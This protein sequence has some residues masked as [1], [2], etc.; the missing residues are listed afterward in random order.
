[1]VVYYVDVGQ[2]RIQ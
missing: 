1:M 2:K